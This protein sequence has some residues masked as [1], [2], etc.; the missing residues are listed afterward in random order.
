MRNT[1]TVIL[2]LFLSTG[3]VYAAAGD[4]GSAKEAKAMVQKAVAYLKTNGPEAAFP[5]FSDP[6]GEFLDR[7][8]YIWVADANAD[9]TCVAHGASA[10]L[11]GR[12]L[13]D[14]KDSDGK[15]FMREIREL[16]RT[17]ESGSVDYKWFRPG[18]GKIEQK[19]VYFETV[20]HYIVACGY[21]K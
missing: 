10:Q 15:P 20:G 21:Y 16:A 13:L 12:T 4:I 17:S 8:L 14:F 6:K 2:T 1:L 9:M 11:V 7:D 18:T 5:A 19:S 3:V